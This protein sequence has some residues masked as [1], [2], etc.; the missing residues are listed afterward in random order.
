LQRN[1]RISWVT[2]LGNLYLKG[3][4]MKHSQSR[5][6]EE[7]ASLGQELA[8]HEKHQIESD[9]REI[10]GQSHQA[11]RHKNLIHDTHQRPQEIVLKTPPT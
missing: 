5:G 3:I 4:D 8:Q 9:S 1:F 11:K 10:W 2:S 7:I 6:I